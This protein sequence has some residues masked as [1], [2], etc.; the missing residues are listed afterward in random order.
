[1]EQLSKHIESLIFAAEHPI[2]RVEIKTCLETLFETMLSDSDLE[3]AY[4]EL[5]E[6]YRSDHYVFEIVEIAEGFRFLSKGA[7]HPTIGAFLKQNAK[8]KLSQSALETLSVI[9]YKQPITKSEVEEI[10][11]VNCDYAVQKL[12]EKEL[13]AIA[14]RSDKAG[15]PLLYS[16][17]PKFMDYFGIKSLKDLPKPKEF[18]ASENEIGAKAE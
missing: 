10:R 1:M 4:A 14:G 5:T 9:A 15:R 12:L 7:Y 2:H 13:L 16:T 6:K 11:G 17:S 8:K 18:S 3:R